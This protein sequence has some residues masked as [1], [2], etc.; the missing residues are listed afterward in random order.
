MKNCSD[1]VLEIISDQKTTI[2][3]PR[4]AHLMTER[5]NERGFYCIRS[6]I[7]KSEIHHEQ[8]GFIISLYGKGAV[9]GHRIMNS[10][11]KSTFTL[12]AVEPTRACFISTDKFL[13]LTASQHSLKEAITKSLVAEINTREQQLLNMTCYSVKQRV[14]AALVHIAETYGYHQNGCSL[15]VRLDRQ[16]IADLAATTKEQVSHILASLKNSGLVNFKA[17]HFKY[18]DLKGLQLISEPA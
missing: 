2:E 4:G 1:E 14:A 9:F 16:E 7:V 12:S 6:G 11:D 5:E 13:K 10:T 3:F 15:Y 18:F 17:R 8:R